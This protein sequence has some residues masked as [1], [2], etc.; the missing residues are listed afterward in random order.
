MSKYQYR[1]PCRELSGYVQYYWMLDLEDVCPSC[2]PHRL[3]TAGIHGNCF[4][5]IGIR[6]SLFCPMEKKLIPGRHFTGSETEF[7][8]VL[9]T[10]RVGLMSVVFTPVGAG[11]LHLPLNELTNRYVSLEEVLGR[12]GK[13]MEEQMMNLSGLTNGW[14]VWSHFLLGRL[15]RRNEFENNRMR[16]VMTR[17]L[18]CRGMFNVEQL[19]SYACLSRKQFERVFAA[20]VGLMP[21]QY[22]RVIRFLYAVEFRNRMPE[23]DLVTLAFHTGYYADAAHLANEIKGF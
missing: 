2:E 23:V 3:T 19:A 18:Q 22:L 11:H 21:K 20:Y 16:M 13:D 12:E 15:Q 10:G 7:I 1:P 4:F 6:T 5:I 9:P 14:R 17:L 8:D